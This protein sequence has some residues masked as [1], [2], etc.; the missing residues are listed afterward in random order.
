MGRIARTLAAIRLARA[1]RVSTAHVG[2][3]SLGKHETVAVGV[4]A[5]DEH[6]TLD[7]SR[8]AVGKTAELE[9][10]EFQGKFTDLVAMLEEWDEASEAAGVDAETRTAEI[11]DAGNAGLHRCRKVM[12]ENCAQ[13]LKMA[14][15]LCKKIAAAVEAHHCENGTWA[16]SRPTR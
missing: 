7:A 6:I 4:I 13:A 8:T 16:R 2:G 14:R 10:K 9:A 1:K 3:S 5:D 11:G 15:L 12:T